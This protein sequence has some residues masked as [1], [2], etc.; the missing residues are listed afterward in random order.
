[1]KDKILDVLKSK[2]GVSSDDLY[3]A[4]GAFSRYTQDQMKEEHGQS[5]RSR[6]QILNAYKDSVSD[7]E[8]M[9]KWVKEVK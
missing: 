9:I 6:E 4:T 2:L 7:C 3:R 1:M 8:S 5:G